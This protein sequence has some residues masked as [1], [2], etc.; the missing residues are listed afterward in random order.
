M[1]KSTAKKIYQLL[2]ELEIKKESLSKK[3]RIE[4]QKQIDVWMEKLQEFIDGVK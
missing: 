4:V 2:V 3:E 1:E